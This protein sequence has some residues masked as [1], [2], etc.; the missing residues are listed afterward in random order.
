MKHCTV[1]F[2]RPDSSEGGELS[3]EIYKWLSGQQQD[4]RLTTN[5]L[6]SPLV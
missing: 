4:N 6:L 5:R 2:L 3:F 1:P